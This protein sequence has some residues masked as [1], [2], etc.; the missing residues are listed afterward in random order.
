MRTKLLRMSGRCAV[1]AIVAMTSFF[2]TCTAGL[3]HIFSI[4]LI[5]LSFA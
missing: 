1:L 3:L 5:R 2:S 4:L